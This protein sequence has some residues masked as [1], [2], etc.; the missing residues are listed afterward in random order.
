M[1]SLVV[2]APVSVWPSL[3]QYNNLLGVEPGD[4]VPVSS[5]GTEPA[6]HL[7]LHTWASDAYIAIAKG[8]VAANVPGTS[9][10]D[11]DALLATLTVS[12]QEDAG[13]KTKSAHF[14][15]VLSALSLQSIE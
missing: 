4:G 7:A 1:R 9:Q 3:R 10:D 6:T 11:V 5:D 2:V 13:G 12:T 15:H 14:N 8:D